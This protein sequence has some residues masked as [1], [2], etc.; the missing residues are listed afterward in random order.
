M[1]KIRSD[2]RQRRENEA[3]FGQP[4]MRQCEAGRVD[5]KVVEQQ[6]VEVQRAR[7][8]GRVAL[9]IA[10]VAALDAQQKIQQ[11]FRRKGGRQ[12]DGC[13]HK[14]GLIRYAHRLGAIQRRAR[15][16]TAGTRQLVD[17][18]QESLL[19]G[20]DLRWKIRT[21][22]DGGEWAHNDTLHHGR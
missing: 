6:Q 16:N 17:R 7:T 11:R 14:G 22:R 8:L 19:R 3:A 18:S 21:Q 13:V 1:T 2:F 20:T 10:P 4:R 9:P 12:R 15:L 5:D